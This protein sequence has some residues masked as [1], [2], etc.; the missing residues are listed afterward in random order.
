MNTQPFLPSCFAVFGHR[1][2]A[3]LAPENTLPSFEQALSLGCRGIELDVHCVKDRQGQTHL[4]VIHDAKVNRTTNSRGL[5]ADFTAEEL[6]G[7]DAG[8]GFGIPLLKDV[9]TLLDTA[10]GT[11]LNIE[12]K[13]AGTAAPTAALLGEHPEQQV[14]VSSFDHSELAKFRALA[15]TCPVAPLFHR[16]QDTLFDTAKALRAV[17]INMSQTMVTKDLIDSCQQAGFGVLVYTVN[18]TEQ[19][20]QLK[21]WGVAG[22]FTDRPDLM[23][24]LQT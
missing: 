12:L 1:G 2:A 16:H 8:K 7:M 24:P 5:V 23:M 3:G 13:G 9:I 14:L 4:C 17:S 11:W 22:I 15:P 18:D 20:Q 10:P 19:G 6:A 21:C